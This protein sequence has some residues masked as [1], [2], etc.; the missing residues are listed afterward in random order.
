MISFWTHFARLVV[1][2]PGPALLA[3][4]WHLTRRG[5]RARHVLRDGTRG[6]G[7]AYD[8]WL[9][10]EKADA[11]AGQALLAAPATRFS[12]L[13][14][15]DGGSDARERQ[16]SHRSVERQAGAAR[17][18][19]TLA[20]AELAELIARADGDYVF[21]LRSGDEL[22]GAALAR[23]GQAIHTT[24]AAIAFGDEDH[25]RRNGRGREPWFKPKW[26]SELFLALDY[27]SSAVA[28][29]RPLAQKVA[30]ELQ[31]SSSFSLDALLLRA[32]QKS[33][34]A[35]AH[36]TSVLVHVGSHGGR[37]GDRRAAVARL[38]DGRGACLPGLFDTVR[39]QWSLPDPP[40][41]VSIIIPTRDKVDL[42]RACID[43]ILLRTDYRPF[44]ILVVDNG[45]QEEVTLA[46]LRSLTERHNVR[47]LRS[48]AEYNFSAL[49][50]LAVRQALGG[51]LLLLN[52][53]TEV[54]SPEW[55]SEM[56]RQAVRSEVGAVGAK[57]LYEDG[58]LQHA[59]VVVGMG[60]AAGHAH[61][62]LPAG[63]PGYFGQPHVAQ[64]VTAVTAACLLV[65][66]K[67]YE[68][69]GGLDEERFAIAYNDV[70]LCLKLREAGWQNI[71]TPHAVLYHHESKSRG[72]DLSPKHR[73][74]YMRELHA[75]QER[76]QTKTFVDPLH[77]PNLDRYSET[78]MPNLG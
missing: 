44:E 55:L 75:L 21:F 49:N 68:V 61:R 56:M 70:D 73:Q 7:L 9:K 37:G 31:A 59:G 32:T 78:Y 5:V 23:L 38:L 24:G 69:V 60:E 45:S 39:V 58:S 1:R 54:I 19:Q 33:A 6:L 10:K 14:H 26:N 74:R 16:R 47:I 35:I 51:Y 43:S 2:R 53:D 76:W 57:L 77:S 17:S 64:F 12:V 62:H 29:A 36:V 4:Y 50:N 71:Y 22:A 3:A 13:I 72:S 34:N 46:Y 65:D 52:N 48:D 66:R 42:L 30:A 20:G 25:G 40:P 15:D 28:I 67:K 63:Q 11:E 18:V 27:L 8:I 41:L